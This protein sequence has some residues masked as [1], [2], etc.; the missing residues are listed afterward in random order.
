MKNTVLSRLIKKL[1]ENRR[2]AYG[3]IVILILMGVIF[4]RTVYRLH[5]SAQEEIEIKKENISILSNLERDQNKTE[6][7]SEERLREIEKGLIEAD[8]PSKATALLQKSFKAIASKN[9]VLV[10]SERPLKPLEAGAYFKVP[11]E[12]Q[13]KTGLPGLKGLLSDLSSSHLLIGIEFFS[14][15][16]SEN[17]TLNAVIIVHGAMKK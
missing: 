13:L 5:S 2:L 11:V 17:G 7:V 3:I 16:N 10:I 8:K 9:N 14:I 4:F 6:Y 12:F 15:K 1:S